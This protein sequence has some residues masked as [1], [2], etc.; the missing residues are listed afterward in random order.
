MKQFRTYL[1]ATILLALICSS[2]SSDEAPDAAEQKYIELDVSIR[3]EERTRVSMAGDEFEDQDKFRIYFYS[4]CPITTAG[5]GQLI[6]V[7]QYAEG[8]KKWSIVVGDSP[9]YWDDRDPAT[10][11]SFCAIMPYDDYDASE[12]TY[13]VQEN[14]T[15]EA[16]YKKSDF[17]IACTRTADRL[18]P[19]AFNHA[20]A[21]LVVKF[22]APEA[23]FGF[24]TLVYN[25]V[26]LQQ[27][28]KTGKAV[29][30]ESE[31]AISVA[32]SAQN[33][34]DIQLFRSTD[35]DNLYF[36]GVLPPQTLAEG[37]VFT[38]TI[39]DDGSPKTYNYKVPQSGF[40]LESGKEA[41]LTLKLKKTG[42]E[43]DNITINPW[44]TITLN[45][46]DNPIKL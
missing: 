21:R 39:T 20:Y 30:T 13:T 25:G 5:G 23:G 2:C 12:Q 36:T 34:A 16:A 40:V 42:L 32:V 8:T 28:K 14:Q 7:Y 35:P 26:T 15:T 18:V 22:D 31:D 11:R 9:I 1:H 4:P 37:T 19:I 17:L 3:S 27:V 33:D 6:S 43:L 44:G 38:M 46:E 24:G 29:Y 45:D 41:T 10:K